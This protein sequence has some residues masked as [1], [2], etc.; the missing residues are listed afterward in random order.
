MASGGRTE[1]QVLEELNEE[2]L[3]LLR[4]VLQI[5]RAKMHLSAYEATDDLLA[6]V[7]EIIP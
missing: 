3:A 6:A 2:E 1:K 7:K 5:E 4:R